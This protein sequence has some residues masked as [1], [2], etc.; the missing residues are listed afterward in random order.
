MQ[1]VESA[2]LYGEFERIGEKVELVAASEEAYLEIDDD[3]SGDA[4]RS[5]LEEAEVDDAVEERLAAL[6][7][8]LS[9]DSK[10]S[11]DSDA[12]ALDDPD[13]IDVEL[14]GDASDESTPD[15]N[16]TTD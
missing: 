16:E 11:R 9:G 6:R 3:L 13:E 1:G 15:A 5:R 14:P 10:L 7:G 12:G 8:E 4:L 2:D